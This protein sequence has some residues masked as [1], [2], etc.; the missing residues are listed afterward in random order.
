MRNLWSYCGLVD[1]KITASD[2]DLPV[3]INGSE[4]WG[5]KYTAG[6]N[7][8]RTLFNFMFESSFFKF[9]KIR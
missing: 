7:D 6:Y 2:K 3:N 8:A 5:R 4:K 9:F 1:A